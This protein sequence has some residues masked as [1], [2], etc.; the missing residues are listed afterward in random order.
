MAQVD[1]CVSN[2]KQ[3]IICAVIGLND[4]QPAIGRSLIVHFTDC[5]YT[6][7]KHRRAVLA[8]SD[9]STNS[10]MKGIVTWAQ[11][12]T[13]LY[14]TLL[15]KIYENIHHQIKAR[16]V[17]LVCSHCCWFMKHWLRCYPVIK[18]VPCI[19]ISPQFTT[20]ITCLHKHTK[21]PVWEP[22]ASIQS[23]KKIVIKTTMY[24]D[25]IK[26]VCELIGNHN[27]ANYSSSDILISCGIEK[28]VML[29]CKD[30]KKLSY[31]KMK[32]LDHLR[33]EVLSPLPLL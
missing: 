17:F 25:A 24:S 14:H 4:K 16:S 28:T 18:D 27:E 26:S 7:G 10:P 8:D 20:T 11:Y 15:K 22:V 21:K 1:M 33:N 32:I 9:Q 29:P 5:R 12:A 3:P 23:V 13:F 19:Q 31:L 30:M 6:S 2:N